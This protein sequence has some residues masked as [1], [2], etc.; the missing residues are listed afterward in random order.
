[1]YD[2]H[3][4]VH[5][6][7]RMSPYEL[8]MGTIRA[9]QKFYSWG[10]IFQKLAK[11]DLYYTVI[12][13]WGKRMLRE[14]W[15]DEE[16]HAY[17]DWLRGQLYGEGGALGNP[18]RTIGVPALLLQEKI[19]QLLQRF[20]GELGVTVVPLAE[21]AKVSGKPREI[22]DRPGSPGSVPNVGESEGPSS[23]SAPINPPDGAHEEQRPLELQEGRGLATQ[24]PHL[25]VRKV[26]HEQGREQAQLRLHQEARRG[27]RRLAHH[28][29]VA[30]GRRQQHLYQPRL[31]RERDDLHGRGSSCRHV[32][33]QHAEQA[34]VGV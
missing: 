27:H 10:G 17:V 20:L 25:H 1:F 4:C 33:H 13:F 15:K 23:P 31:R 22:E 32:L 9:M 14:W 16:N 21:A 6:P 30:A 28:D 5:Q 2:G 34:V 3:H 19:G 12:R 11:G 7:R 24:D 29:R 18:V 8:Q 26:A